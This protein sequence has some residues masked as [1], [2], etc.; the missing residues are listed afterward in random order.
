M[1]PLL[2]VLRGGR[3]KQVLRAERTGLDGVPGPHGTGS[4]R[5]AADTYVTAHGQGLH[6]V[7]WGAVAER[8]KRGG[9][10]RGCSFLAERLLAGLPFTSLCSG[11]HEMKWALEKNTD[12][13]HP[14]KALTKP[15]VWMGALIN[16]TPSS[17][18]YGSRACFGQMLWSPPRAPARGK[19]RLTKQS[20]THASQGLGAGTAKGQPHPGEGRGV[21][22]G[23]IL[24]RTSTHSLA[25]A[26]RKPF[27]RFSPKG[28]R[29]LN[30]WVFM[31]RER[32]IERRPF[33]MDSGD[34]TT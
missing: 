28:G 31:S 26:T 3:G 22:R 27:S 16:Y 24:Q 1:E 13:L 18:S 32:H 4:R 33:Q 7:G 2:G 30:T 9:E 10:R 17:L 11:A 5:P 14:W 25:S 29:D 23:I 15:L 21:P 19:G 6:R 34:G 8:K 12:V 20:G